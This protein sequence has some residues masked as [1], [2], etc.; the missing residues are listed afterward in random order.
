MSIE[1]PSHQSFDR[2]QIRNLEPED[3]SQLATLEHEVWQANP[4]MTPEEANAIAEG[5]SRHPLLD[6]ETI[7][8]ATLGDEIV[9]TAGYYIDTIDL[10]ESPDIASALTRLTSEPPSLG[11]S[12]TFGHI[13][14]L[15]TR[16]R[17]RGQGVATRLGVAGLQAI[18]QGGHSLYK[19]HLTE[20]TK[21]T[22][23]TPAAMEEYGVVEVRDGIPGRGEHP[24]LIRTRFIGKV[25]SS[26]EALRN[27]P[28]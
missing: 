28:Q 14:E 25:D 1:L 24:D 26:L 20:A 18:Q 2:F 15:A 12:A 23:A 19:F 13:Y 4:L 5:R 7:L 16:P 11:K 17:F 3:T 27:R 10:E 22:V 6:H 9:G 21:Q 8:V